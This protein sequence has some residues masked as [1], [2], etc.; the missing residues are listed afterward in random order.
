MKKNVVPSE[1]KVLSTSTFSVDK[2]LWS[3]EVGE[4]VVSLSTP[5]VFLS[6]VCWIK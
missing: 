2:L 3:I 5:F 4:S 6:Y 1:S